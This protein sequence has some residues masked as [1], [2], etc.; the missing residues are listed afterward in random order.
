MHENLS[1]VQISSRDTKYLC[2]DVHMYYSVKKCITE[3][4]T[5][6]D[7]FSL[8]TRIVY[9]IQSHIVYGLCV[10]LLENIQ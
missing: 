10:V 7:M 5:V 9:E 8:T 1:G 6:H 2:S 3:S 4:S